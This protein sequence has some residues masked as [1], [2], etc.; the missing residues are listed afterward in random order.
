MI[1]YHDGDI[2]AAWREY[3][4]TFTDRTKYPAEW[5][6]YPA[7]WPF[8]M[9]WVYHLSGGIQT[10]WAKTLNLVNWLFAGL[11]I[12]LLARR[13][14]GSL[15]LLAGAL[16]VLAPLFHSQAFAG[17]AELPM[18][19]MLFGA[20]YLF[21]ETEGYTRY[22]LPGLLLVSAGF[23]KDEGF[24]FAFPVAVVMLF[25]AAH[26][27]KW[28]AWLLLPALFAAGRL[29]LWGFDQRLNYDLP[30]ELFDISIDGFFPRLT[31]SASVVFRALFLHD[32]FG[33]VPHLAV[34][35]P[36]LLIP[37]RPSRIA[38][39]SVA[40]IGLYLLAFIFMGALSPNRVFAYY[41]ALT[42]V[43]RFCMNTIPYLCYLV[44]T[45]VGG[46]LNAGRGASSR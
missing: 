39:Y 35:L 16:F 10:T 27:K 7:G 4:L 5:P 12:M 18:I 2:L 34:L 23:I 17:Y 43:E 19:L 41:D 45:S 29:L 37:F 46:L 31:H 36:I 13:R 20:F 15:S 33:I 11:S 24:Y 21:T 1:A 6:L 26:R 32:S 25:D 30:V 38:M 8:V 42:V 3:L 14:L 40:I 9:S 28:L 22:V 44:T